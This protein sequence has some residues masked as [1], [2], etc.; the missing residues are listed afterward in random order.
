MAYVPRSDI[1]L[2]PFRY[3]L[4]F[5]DGVLFNDVTA[6]QIY[7]LGPFL[8]EIIRCIHDNVILIVVNIYFIYLFF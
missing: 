4:P 8:I 3:L 6:F 5:Q 7:A 1:S 2:L